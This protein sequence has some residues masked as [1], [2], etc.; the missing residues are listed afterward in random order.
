MQHLWLRLAGL[1]PIIALVVGVNVAVDPVHVL[2]KHRYE[3]GIARMLLAGHNVTNISNPHE[4]AYLR[5]Y[6]AGLTD[7]KDVLVLGSSRSKL[8]RASFFPGRTFF[9]NSISGAG[10]VDYLA[11]Y[12]LY[13][14]RGRIPAQLVMELSPWL[15]H[16][17]YASIWEDFNKH[18]AELEARVLPLAQPAR[19][20]GD[21]RRPFP[22]AYG[23][24]LSPGYFQTSLFTGLRQLRMAKRAPSSYFEYRLGD[25]P[26]GETLLTDGSTVYA[27]PARSQAYVEKVRA[28]ALAYAQNP[29]GIPAEI[30]VPQ[31]AVLEAFMRQLQQEGIEILFYLPPYH[32]DTYRRLV[33]SERYQ[34]VVDVQRTWVQLAQRHH[35]AIV[36]SY[37]PADVAMTD[38]DFFDGSH[39]TAAGMT[40]LFTSPGGEK[41]DRNTGHW[42]EPMGVPGL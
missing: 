41:T 2:G 15:V 5:Y 28:D 8:I 16:G 35:I 31:L 7:R 3:A 20:V 32:P 11:I 1:L 24:L 13:Q 14:Q 37:N 26:L 9:N 22:K 34:I 39:L 36:G 4:A 21:W 30:D 42:L 12:A 29:A 27:E 10:L 25:L 38:S 33:S 6:V 18:K 17:Q 19:A 40:R 23:E